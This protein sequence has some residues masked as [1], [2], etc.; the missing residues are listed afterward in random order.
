MT[1]QFKYVRH[2]STAVALEL[3]AEVLNAVGERS[4][5]LSR[6]MQ[7]RAQRWLDSSGR[8]AAQASDL[9]HPPPLDKLRQS[10]K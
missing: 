1:S 3:S 6:G 10:S 7:E 9:L 5:G 8:H 2:A 4:G